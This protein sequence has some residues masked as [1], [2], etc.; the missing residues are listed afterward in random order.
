MAEGKKGIRGTQGFAYVMTAPTVIILLLMTAYPV[1]FTVVYSF[2]DYNYL[3]GTH[4]F[5]A[6]ENYVS[7]FQNIYF[8]QAVVN[9]LVFTVLAVVLETVLGL[10]LALYVKSLKRG[11][12]IFRTLVLLPY[13]LPAVTVAL[14][15]RMMLSPNYGVV[16][17]VFTSLGLPVYN[18]FRDVNTAFGT[19][20]MI[21]VWQN[22]PFAF[23]LVYASLQGVPESQYEAAAIDGAGNF[24]SFW[25][26]TLPNIAGGIALCAMLRTIDTFRLFEKVNILTGGGPANTTTTITQFM[27]NYGIKNLD[28]G[29]ASACA[30][31]M[32]A[33]VLAMSGIYVKKAMQ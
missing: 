33:F 32:A 12:K 7:L 31:V 2:T 8:R 4:T 23:L 25:H 26:V 9:T 6:L 16:T 30:I 28:F 27:Y 5:I 14:I 1:V 13:L 22:V 18:W 11:Q 17:Q 20:L 3:K 29:F 21:D 19:I 15:W 10:L 24:Q